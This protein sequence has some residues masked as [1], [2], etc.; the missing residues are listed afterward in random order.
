MNTLYDEVVSRLD[1]GSPLVLITLVEQ[2]GS[3][4]RTAGARMI[5]A[6]DGGIAG[7][8]GGGRYEAEAIAAALGL[9]AKGAAD[10]ACETHPAVLMSYSLHGTTDMDMLCGGELTLLLEYITDTP[11]NRAVFTA[12]GEAQADGVP[13]TLLTRLVFADA[14]ENPVKA[15]HPENGCKLDIRAER[16]IW[17]PNSGLVPPAPL[18]PDLASR[19]AALTGDVP[20]R[21]KIGSGHYLLEPFARPFRLLIFGGG[22]VSRETAALAHAVGFRVTVAEDRPEFAAPER[23]KGCATELLPGL[24]ENDCARL[25]ERFKPG[26]YDGIAIMT[27]GHAHDRDALAAALGTGAGY[28]GMIGSRGKRAAVYAALERGGAGKA[29]LD[30]V[31]SPIGLCIG[32]QTPVEIAVSIVAELIAWRAGARV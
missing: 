27:R 20:V 3:A 5:V 19:I 26:L 15:T 2:H 22:H 7:T 9:C 17:L 32:A 31:K 25:L 23:F 13:V 30:A 24:G 6:P 14:H 12:A 29:A 16:F 11:R 18:S 4:P 8:V 28:I 21:I 10:S 1:Q